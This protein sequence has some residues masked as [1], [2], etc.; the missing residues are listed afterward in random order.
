MDDYTAFVTAATGLDAA[1][2][3]RYLLYL[4]SASTIAGLVAPWLQARLPGWQDHAAATSTVSDDRAVRVA[5]VALQGLLMIVSVTAWLVPRF[6]V[7]LQAG[8]ESKLLEDR[9]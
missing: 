4:V 7:G 1:T 2:L 6:T 9:K 5:G 8:R 3:G